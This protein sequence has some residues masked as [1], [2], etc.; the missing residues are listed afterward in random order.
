MTTQNN[1]GEYATG[2]FY[3]F[4][5]DITAISS[6]GD[7]I[8]VTT[9]VDHMF[10]VGNQVSFSI[11]AEY[12][13]R[14]LSGKTGYVTAIPDTDQITVNINAFDFNSFTAPVAAFDPAQVMPIGDSNYGTL[15]PGGIPVNPN[16]IPGAFNVTQTP[17]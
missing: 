9:S 11:P 14:Q 2:V 16:T 3:P 13:M 5:C 4:R 17:S 7:S 1:F 10:S 15:S 12:G 8:L 6:V